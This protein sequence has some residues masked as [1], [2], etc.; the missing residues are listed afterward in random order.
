MLKIIILPTAWLFNGYK[1]YFLNYFLKQILKYR[2][3]LIIIIN[4]LKATLY[5]TKFKQFNQKNKKKSLIFIVQTCFRKNFDR[6][7][8][9]RDILKLRMYDDIYAK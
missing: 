8:L 1:V 5:Y 7:L 3:I 2:L 9:I 4:I 6:C